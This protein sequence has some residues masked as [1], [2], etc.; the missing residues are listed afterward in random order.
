MS[1]KQIKSVAEGVPTNLKE[2]GE[3][4]ITEHTRKTYGDRLIACINTYIQTNNLEKYVEHRRKKKSESESES[5]EASIN[6]DATDVTT[7]NMAS[8]PERKVQNG[9]T[10]VR[11]SYS[12]EY[13]PSGKKGGAQSSKPAPTTLFKQEN[14]VC[15]RGKLS[16]N[17]SSESG[18]ESG[19][20]VHQIT[21]VWAMGLKAIL[22][23]PNN[24]KKLCHEFEYVH[25]CSADESMT[26]PLSGKYT[27]WFYPATKNGVASKTKVN[28][29][30]IT[31]RF[32]ENNEGYHNVEG[33]GSNKFGK[34]TITGT[35]DKDRIVTLFRHFQVQK[36]KISSDA[37]IMR[38]RKRKRRDQHPLWE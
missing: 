21:G 37:R 35:L 14:V 2:L 38:V 24:E 33:N 16:R 8:E 23:D 29:L 32:I 1:H 34:Y 36:L 9:E 27:G 31:L 20:M 11:S 28:E 12:D 5:V 7:N 17:K 26:F 25:K 19:D 22:E 3:Y 10:N 6:K 15:L 18:S 4:N 13:S 30:D